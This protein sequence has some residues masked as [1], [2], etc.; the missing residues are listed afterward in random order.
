M[1]ILSIKIIQIIAGVMT[2]AYLLKI[3]GEEIRTSFSSHEIK[4]T[5]PPMTI[6]APAIFGVAPG[7]FKPTFNLFCLP[8]S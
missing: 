3:F 2:A 4:L 8:R 6:L 7:L 1:N 5:L